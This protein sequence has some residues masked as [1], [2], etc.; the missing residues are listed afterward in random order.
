MSEGSTTKIHRNEEKEIGRYLYLLTMRWREFAEQPRAM[1]EKV[2]LH[3]KEAPKKC[4]EFMQKIL[5]KNHASVFPP[6]K[7]RN[8]TEKVCRLQHLDS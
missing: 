8:K 5:N 4:Q 2:T 6:K 1:Y 7:L 3:K